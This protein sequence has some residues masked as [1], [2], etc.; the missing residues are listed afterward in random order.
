MAPDVEL[1]PIHCRTCD[2]VTLHRACGEQTRCWACLNCGT[3][4]RRMTR[5]RGV[6]EGEMRGLGVDH[7]RRQP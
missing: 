7:D 6:V 2:A 1:N 5:P 4:E 3:L